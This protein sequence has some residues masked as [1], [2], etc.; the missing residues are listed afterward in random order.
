MTDNKEPIKRKICPECKGAQF[1]DVIVR[2]DINKCPERCSRTCGICGGHGYIYPASLFF[3]LDSIIEISNNKY[4]HEQ[5]KDVL[6]ETIGRYNIENKTYFSPQDAAE[7]YMRIVIY[8]R[9][10]TKESYAFSDFN[11]HKNGVL[12][13]NMVFIRK[14]IMNDNE[15]LL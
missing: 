2:K 7:A 15:D 4:S 10:F 14:H 13:E 5:L 3:Y 6:S 11:S 8:N 12:K 1:F 9:Y